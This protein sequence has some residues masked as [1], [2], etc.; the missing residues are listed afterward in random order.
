[1]N[2]ASLS[3]RATWR[4]RSSSLDALNPAL[5]PGRVLPVAFPSAGPLPSTTSATASAALFGGFAGTTE[6]SEFP[7]SSIKGLRP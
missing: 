6:P 5:S 1:M 4:T 2:R 7:R 3:F